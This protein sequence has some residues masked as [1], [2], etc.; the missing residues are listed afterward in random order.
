MQIK[1]KFLTIFGCDI[2]PVS[3]DGGKWE[4]AASQQHQSCLYK[5]TG[6]PMGHPCFSST[7]QGDPDAR[8]GHYRHLLK[9]SCL[10][11]LT[12]FSNALA[13]SVCIHSKEMQK[14]KLAVCKNTGKEKARSENHWQSMAGQSRRRRQ[15]GRSQQEPVQYEGCWKGSFHFRASSLAAWYQHFDSKNNSFMIHEIINS[16][17]NFPSEAITCWSWRNSVFLQLTQTSKNWSQEVD[18]WIQ[19]YH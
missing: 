2:L 12:S 16:A 1:H 11:C 17:T 14:H 18:F 9:G 8:F 3:S 7:G 5:A 4:S 19:S 13:P 6:Q 15:S 10:A